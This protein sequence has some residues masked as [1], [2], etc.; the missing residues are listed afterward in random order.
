MAQQRT[1]NDLAAV[2][3]N[4]T[5]GELMEVCGTFSDMTAKDNG[6]RPARTKTPQ[7]FASLLHDWAEVQNDPDA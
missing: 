3:L 5:Y 4:M 1:A 7:D 6:A 2:I